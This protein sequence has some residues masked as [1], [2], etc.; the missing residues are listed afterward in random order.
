MSL[1]MRGPDELRTIVEAAIQ[2]AVTERWASRLQAR[3]TTIWTTDPAV[4]A[5]IGNRLGWLDAPVSFTDEIA[6]LEAWAGGIR[7]VGFT[8][9]VVCGMGGSSLAPDV[10]AQVLPRSA[11]GIRVSVLDST[12]PAA[13]AAM[14]ASSDPASTLWVIATKSGTTT[15]SLAFLAHYWAATQHR[16]GRFPA[17]DTG[18]SFV[19]VTD[20]GDSL[21]AIPHSDV[22][23]ET[24]LNPP[25]VGGRYSALTYVGLVP[26]ALLGLDPTALLQDANAMLARCHTDD[27]A[28]PGLAL[29]AAMGALARAGRD[30]LT[31]VIEPDLAPVGAWLEQLIAESTGKHGTGVVP[32]D[33]EPLGA[34][35]VY[36]TDRVFVRLGRPSHL[37]DTDAATEALVAA[38]HPVIDLPL[39][40]GAWVAGEFVRWEVATA[41]AGAVLEVD[42]FDEPNVTESKTN[43]RAALEQHHRDG[44]FPSEEP[45]AVSGALRLYGDAGLAAGDA[46]AVLRA[47]LGRAR[48]DGYHAI[49]AY[50]AP[51]E[52]R[53]TAL[54]T[55]QARLRDGTTH[56]TTL[57][58]GPRFLH[59]TG[60][61]HKGGTPSGCFLQLVASHPEDV[62]IPGRD[63]TFGVLID[64]Q[65]AGDRASLASH[66]LPCLRI[67]LSDDPDAGIAELASLLAAVLA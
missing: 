52:E 58:Y 19:A 57:G 4:A 3:D 27:A 53:T 31:F 30:K 41:I 29:G 2:R 16:V 54:R 13:V 25:D 45:I 44:A 15:E 24:F 1:A 5:T 63:E 35:A 17:S 40:A 28:N 62:P 48:A 18:D 32:V 33:G 43:T 7:E 47:H 49:Q 37:A 56:A 12:D 46:A 14:D 26:A 66:G 59:S 34:P 6:E 61:L 36:G 67:H 42:P 51:T 11:H 10:L 20:P 8:H 65:A 9:A 21:A 64:A 50:L 22:F 38:G 55:L 39:E 60:Q 23:R